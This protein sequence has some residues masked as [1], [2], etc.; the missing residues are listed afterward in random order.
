[1][2]SVYVSGPKKG[3]FAKDPFQPRKL[4]KNKPP[5]VK[6]LSRSIKK[7]QRSTELK[8]I[9]IFLSAQAVS[10][11][12]LFTLLNPIG[13]GD[14]ASARTGNDV[15]A[16]SIQFRS[17]FS[18]NV[19]AGDA[20]PI[21]R[22]MIIWDRQPNGA[23]PAIAD[24]LDNSTITSLT[25]APYNENNQKRFKILYDNRF[26]LVVG[27]SVGDEL[28]NQKL[29]QMKRSLSRIVKY[30]D[31][32]ADITD[33]VSNS[34]LSVLISTTAS[35]SNPPTGTIGFRFYYKDL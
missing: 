25:E 16:T 23:V 19:T 32:A 1:M 20:A 3:R 5:N 8:H 31:A 12:A 11:T 2:T 33:L 34:L 14:G 17:R 21:I 10:T 28:S 30:D 24:V 35:G 26:T 9:D 15:Q 13:V 7:I 4:R 22:H 18:K 29:F 6:S 27:S